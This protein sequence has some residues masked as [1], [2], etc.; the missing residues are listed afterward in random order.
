[1][2]PSPSPCPRALGTIAEASAS[3]PPFSLQGFSA[4]ISAAARFAEASAVLSNL[5]VEVISVLGSAL[6]PELLLELPERQTRPSASA[7]SLLASFVAAAILAATNRPH[8]PQ[9]SGDRGSREFGKLASRKLHDSSPLALPVPAL[10]SALQLDSPLGCSE[11]L[12]EA[13]W[14]P[15][16]SIAVGQSRPPF[17]LPGKSRGCQQELRGGRGLFSLELLPSNRGGRHLGRA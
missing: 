8:D 14:P 13:P 5:S 1:M 6:R 15:L 4:G 9:L 3:V 12:H 7:S 11:R 16:L 17:W 10:R 2:F